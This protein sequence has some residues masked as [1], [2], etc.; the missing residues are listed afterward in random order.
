MNV[1]AIRLMVFACIFRGALFGMLLRAV[2]PEHHL[3]AD[4]KDTVRVAMGLD[5]DCPLFLAS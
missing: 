1:I 2:L 5:D 3:S 4:L